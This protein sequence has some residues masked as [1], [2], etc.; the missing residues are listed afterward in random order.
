MTAD[1]RFDEVA[2]SYDAVVQ[3][4]IGPSGETVQFFADL[5][6]RLMA[7]ALR[8]RG[9]R[10]I[11]D[12]GCGIG[13]TTRAIAALF[14]DADVLGFDVSMESLDVARATTGAGSKIR[15]STSADAA[16]PMDDASAD[17]V[18]TSCVFHHI[19]PRDRERWVRELRRVLKPGG[20]LFL[21]EHNPFNPLT[22]RVVRHVP[23]DEGVELLRPGEAR[24][25]LQACGLAVGPPQFYFF[26]PHA[27]RALRSF[28]PMLRRVPLGA[29][30]FVVG[31]RPLNA[32]D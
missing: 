11:V 3:Q 10:S 14:A 9:V 7:T 15:Y 18:F 31:Q 22:V 25:L 12:F 5:K 29:Q 27:M 13:N 21:F 28:E 24:K 30:Y 32:R 20:A 17:V 23:F 1:G 26:F 2:R 4:A 8:G 6:V 16:L 19:E